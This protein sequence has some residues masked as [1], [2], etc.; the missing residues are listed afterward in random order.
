MHFPPVEGPVGQKPKPPLDDESQSKRFIEAAQQLEA[1]E[2]CTS[3]D[4]VFRIVALSAWK[5]GP[6]SPKDKV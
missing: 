1:D 6:S 2:A 5:T 4:D 3:F